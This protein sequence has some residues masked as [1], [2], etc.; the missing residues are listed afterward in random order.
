MCVCVTNLLMGVL[1]GENKFGNFACTLTNDFVSVAYK[2]LVYTKR[3][4][5]KIEIYNHC[6]NR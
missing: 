1:Y 3:D 4:T 2:E 5:Y 6:K